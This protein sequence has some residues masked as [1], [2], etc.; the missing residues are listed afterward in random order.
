M[1]AV[2]ALKADF[3]Q[4]MQDKKPIDYKLVTENITID[5]CS[6]NIQ[7]V[8]FL[9]NYFD[10]YPNLHKIAV[11]LLP[12]VRGHHSEVALEKLKN[13]ISATI[14]IKNQKVTILSKYIQNEKVQIPKA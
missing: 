7:D 1:T 10:A 14:E 8:I 9:G 3:R 12:Y 6:C 5:F 2:F 11:K 4:F 13:L